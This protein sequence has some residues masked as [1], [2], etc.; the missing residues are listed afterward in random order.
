MSRQTPWTGLLRRAGQLARLTVDRVAPVAKNALDA[1][2]LLQQSM[3]RLIDLRAARYPIAPGAEWAPGEPLRLLLAGYAGSRNTGADVR[4]EEMIRQFRHLF[5]DEHVALSILTIDAAKTR[6]YF[7]TVRQIPTPQ[8]FPKFLFDVVTEQHGVIACEG[9]MFKSKFAN[10]LSTFM[11][12]ALGLATAEHKIAVGYGGEAGAMDPSLEALVRTYCKDATIIARNDN[13][14]RILG[15]LGIAA[16]SGTD[17]AWT[18]TPAPDEVGRQRLIDAGWDGKAPVLALCPINPFWW[19]VKA[20][21]K[22][23]IERAAFKLH[24]KDHYR[25]VYFHHGGPEVEA[26][27]DAYLSAI[28]QATNRFARD[29]DVFVILVGME[30]LDRLACEALQPKLDVPSALFISD[31]HDMYTLVSVLRQCSA[32]VSSRY[33]AIVTSMPG[34]V[35]SAGITMDERIRNLMIDRG[36]PALSLEVDDPALADKLYHTLVHLRDDADGVRERI[37]DCVLT[38][39]E[40]MGVMGQSLVEIVREHH[41]AFPF[42]DGLGRAGSPWDHLPAMPPVWQARVDARRDAQTHPEPEQAA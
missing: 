30:M 39:L 28:A 8:I 11:V 23:G 22:K 42:R 37:V 17:T 2:K 9:S 20:D 36:E 5:G 33:H 34:E 19:P 6:G 13:S 35:P 25:S 27:Q 41:P 32:L 40:R 18:F 1:D 38:N 12:G 26:K 29:G 15:N 24:D 16:E 31:E 7:K 10:A 21:L 3:A 14:V 4:V